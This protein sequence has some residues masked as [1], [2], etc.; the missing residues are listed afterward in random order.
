LD[1]PLAITAVERGVAQECFPGLTTYDATG[2]VA[3][4]LAESWTQDD[5][6]TTFTLR[7]ATWSDGKPVTA[8]DVQ[9][10]L[11]RALDP[12]LAA[13]FAGRLAMIAGATE[14]R[15]GA[16]AKTLGISVSGRRTVRITTAARSAR[17]LEALAEPV[18]ACVPR[19]EVLRAGAEWVRAERPVCSGA[20]A[21]VSAPDAFTL[22]RNPRF[23]GPAAATDVVQFVAADSFEAA[24]ERVRRGEG[25]LAWGFPPA[26]AV[27]RGWRSV[28]RPSPS[29]VLMFV[30]V[31]ITRPKLQSREV[32]HALGMT[33]PRERLIRNLRLSD[34]PIAAAVAYAP[35]PPSARL[36]P[37]SHPAPYQPLDTDDRIEI[38]QV[39]LLE[40][41]ITA[42]S[43]AQ[44]SFIFPAGR[45][46]GA[47]AKGIADAWSR[48]GVRLELREFTAAAFAEALVS[49]DF[50]L[51]LTTS[52]AR[53]TGP[54][55]YLQ[56]LAGRGGPENVSRYAEADF[57]RHLAEADAAGDPALATQALGNAEAMLSEDQVILPLFFFTPLDAVAG[58]VR[59]WEANVRGIHPLRPIRR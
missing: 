36:G 15:A 29:Q 3:P 23:F 30:A 45:L 38:A 6:T 49:G 58:A 28:V 44:F 26:I 21:P 8:Q 1:P 20:L 13:P 24:A 35:V 27:E 56:V 16:P 57:E 51:A 42:K 59:G 48:I 33:L 18:A 19:H 4:G 11:A 53:D 37:L 14:V 32:R 47:L 34:G 54:W 9:F 10:S 22:V 2:A 52:P 41:A 5:L 7:D 46:H 50:D 17:L 43:P 55:P 12:A 40:E 25:D 31:N 39:L